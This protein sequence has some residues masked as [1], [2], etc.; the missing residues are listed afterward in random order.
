MSMDRDRRGADAVEVAEDPAR[1]V[2]GF[3]E[4]SSFLLAAPAGTLLAHGVEA[5]VPKMGCA[6]GSWPVVDRV[7]EFF[8]NANAFGRR[9]PVVVGAVPF[10]D[11]LPA[12]L[13]L[14]SE[15]VRAGSHETAAGGG[16]GAGA[17]ARRE[18][19]AARVAPGPDEYVRGVRRALTRVGRG[20]LDSVLLGRC[21]ELPGES[22]DPVRAVRSLAGR[23]DG[24]AFAVALPRRGE[25]GSRD[26]YGPAPE[27]GRT[28]VGSTP[29]VLV[30]R[31]GPWVTVNATAGALPRGR[32]EAEDRQR[33]D[34]L[35]GSRRHRDEHAL[36]VAALAEAVRSMCRDVTVA[37][38]PTATSSASSWHLRTTVTGRLRDSETSSLSVA[39]AVHE[40]STVR[41]SPV[42]RSVA[43]EGEPFDR[44]FFCGL[45]GWCDSTGDG[46]WTLADRCAEIEDEA[47]RVFAGSGVV[48]GS[49][50]D[51]ELA[52]TTSGLWSAAAALCGD[53]RP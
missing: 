53:E 17:D 1:L 52:A 22:V 14:P 34:E 18:R 46:D 25:D 48:A 42:A 41:G 6:N 12:H 36:E 31:R 16:P 20:E 38:R 3:R 33:A 37:E 2:R 4:D 50:P 35:L 45:V 32:D 11:S 24:G 21:L 30:S 10:D 8:D 26:S 28:L 27:L 19:G 5:T 40:A 13:V 39:T 51:A 43:T 44:G 49:D 9:D 7:A 23:A 15:V 47:L 29:D